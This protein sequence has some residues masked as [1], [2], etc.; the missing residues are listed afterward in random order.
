MAGEACDRGKVLLNGAPV[1]ASRDILPGVM[2]RIDLGSGVLEFE[3]VALPEGNVSRA[4]AQTCYRIHH[5]ERGS[6]FFI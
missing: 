4:E 5:D 1:K 2:I 6:R 3:V